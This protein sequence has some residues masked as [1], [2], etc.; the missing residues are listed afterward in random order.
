YAM[1]IIMTFLPDIDPLIRI[2]IALVG[3]GIALLLYRKVKETWT[4]FMVSALSLFFYLTVL[5]AV[6]VELAIDSGLYHT[7][8][9]ATGALLLLVVGAI[10]GRRAQVLRTR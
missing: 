5:Y 9:F 10:I 1:G 6:D 7:M 8:Q 4:A 3:I 2:W